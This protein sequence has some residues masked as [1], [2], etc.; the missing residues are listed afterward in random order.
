MWPER[1][2]EACRRDRS[3]AIAHGKEDLCPAAPPKTK[4]GLKK[5]K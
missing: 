5:A 1:V 2:T 3:I 4:R